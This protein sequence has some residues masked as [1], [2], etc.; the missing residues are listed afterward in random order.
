MTIVVMYEE[1]NNEGTLWGEVG[2]FKIIFN[3]MHPLMSQR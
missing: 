3:Q 2:K 1:I